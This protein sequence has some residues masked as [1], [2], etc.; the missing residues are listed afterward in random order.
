MVLKLLKSLIIDLKLLQ[1]KEESGGPGSERIENFQEKNEVLFSNRIIF[2]ETA[3]KS[4][5]RVV[6][7][8]FFL[9]FLPCP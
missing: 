9:G 4:S 8:F 2:M 7:V 1:V 3:I 6:Q 5:K